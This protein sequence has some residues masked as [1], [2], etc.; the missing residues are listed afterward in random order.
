DGA[1]RARD[2]PRRRRHP[3][4]VPHR[5]EDAVAGIGANRRSRAALLGRH[6]RFAH[7]RHLSAHSHRETSPPP[8]V[9]IERGSSLTHGGALVST[10]RS[11]TTEQRAEGRSDA[12]VNPLRPP[13]T[14]NSKQSD[15][16]LTA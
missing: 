14:A 11:T 10:G 7:H 12:L 4:R 15:W 3:G 16:A 5:R 13:I 9:L 8:T 2:D 1:L 6:P